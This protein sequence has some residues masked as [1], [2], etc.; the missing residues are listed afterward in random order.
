[1]LGFPTSLLDSNYT[2]SRER[3]LEDM[4]AR[5]LFM[6]DRLQS[7]IS[8]ELEMFIN[9][10]K[11]EL[12][13]QDKIDSI[14]TQNSNSNILSKDEIDKILEDAKRQEKFRTIGNMIGDIGDFFGTMRSG[15]LTMNRPNVG[16]IQSIPNQGI[17]GLNTL[18]QGI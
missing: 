18:L 9:N 12:E 8:P 17:L 15:P 14:K 3:M 7:G 6:P 10:R 1:M 2:N 16:Q 4:L 11:S 13:L 5:K